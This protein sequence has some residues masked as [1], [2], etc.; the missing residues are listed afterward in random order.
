MLSSKL[1]LF[2]L[3]FDERLHGTSGTV[4]AT[5][6]SWQGASCLLRI[7]HILAIPPWMRFGIVVVKLAAPACCGADD[8]SWRCHEAQ[9]TQL[10][11]PRQALAQRGFNEYTCFTIRACGGTR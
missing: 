7:V 3:L 11:N 8:D 10:G 6:P 1:I 5:V 2:L 4:T 9:P